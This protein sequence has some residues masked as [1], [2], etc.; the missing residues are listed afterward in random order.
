MSARHV[1]SWNLAVMLDLFVPLIAGRQLLRLQAI[2]PKE[3]NFQKF[4]EAQMG[5]LNG[6]MWL[7]IHKPVSFTQ[8]HFAI[9]TSDFDM[10]T[11]LHLSAHLVLSPHQRALGG[12]Q[13]L[14]GPA[15]RT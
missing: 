3:E 8:L 2:T 12:V 1:K 7:G 4:S 6:N 5:H 14:P 10:S 15:G 13:G 11:C 9:S